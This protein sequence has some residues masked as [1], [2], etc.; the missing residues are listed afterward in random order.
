MSSLG[1]APWGGWEGT[2]RQKQ[3]IIHKALLAEK[4][5][6]VCLGVSYVPQFSLGHS[7]GG[8]VS[9]VRSCQVFISALCVFPLTVHPHLQ[10]MG[11]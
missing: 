8:L 5:L 10:E 7:P 9:P 3:S 11:D 6:L 2:D 1:L 4:E